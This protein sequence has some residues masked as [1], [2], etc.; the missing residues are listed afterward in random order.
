MTAALRGSSASAA[1]T[2]RGVILSTGS[3]GPCHQR[4]TRRRR[5]RPVPPSVAGI[6]RANAAGVTRWAA[7]RQS[8]TQATVL[9]TVAWVSPKYALTQA[10]T[11]A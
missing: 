6:A 5:L 1:R 8:T 4:G 2:N 10:C 9:R 3:S 11:F 7:N